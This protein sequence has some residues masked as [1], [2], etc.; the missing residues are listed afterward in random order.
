MLVVA[1]TSALLAL[2]A[3]ESLPLLDGL[4]GEVRV[5]PAV[6]HECTLSGRASADILATY[7]RGKVTD[8]DLTELVIAAG[9]LGRGELEAMALYKRLRADRLFIDDRRA[10][11]VAQV[12]GVNVIGS[13]G[14]LV[15]AKA[16]G[17][18]PAV[19]PSLDSIRAAGIY[20][21]ERLV[22]EALQLA[23]EV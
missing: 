1:D 13:I 12:N 15:L 21:S 20:L 4:F 8:V 3:C 22:L 14:V 9:G 5:P 11:R 18:I 10:R 6:F 17:L 2:S 16:H 7:L 23:G 19:R